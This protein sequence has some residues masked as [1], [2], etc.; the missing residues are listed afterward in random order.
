MAKNGNAFFVQVSRHIFDKQYHD[1]K[2]EAKVLYL[3]LHELEAKYTTGERNSDG[4]RAHGI[5][6]DSFFRS[7]EDL[8]K[9][10]GWSLSKVKRA[11]K[12]LSSYPELVEIKMIPLKNSDSALKKHV[13]SYKILKD[14]KSK[15]DGS[16][17]QAGNVLKDGYVLT[18]SD[19]LALRNGRAT[20]RDGHFWQT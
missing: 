4:T 20:I 19:I 3:I 13:T 2:D 12:A 11:K 8:A 1:M 6:K 15:K 9:D 16:E 14:E 7:D 10:T 18:E 17:Y 5:G